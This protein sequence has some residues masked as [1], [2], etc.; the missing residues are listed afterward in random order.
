MACVYPRVFP[1]L[2][3][4]ST[5]LPDQAVGI[6]HETLAGL[7]VDIEEDRLQA[8]LDVMGRLERHLFKGGDDLQGPFV[9]LLRAQAASW[10][11]SSGPPPGSGPR[12][13]RLMIDW[14]RIGFD[15]R[16]LGFDLQPRKGVAQPLDETEALGRARGV[17]NELGLDSHALGTPRFERRTR[18][19]GEELEIRLPWLDPAAESM[20]GGWLV[21]FSQGR[22]S[23][24][25]LHW[26]SGE[27]RFTNEASL[28]AG[29]R[30][31]LVV[32]LGLFLAVRYLRFYDSGQVRIRRAVQMGM[33]VGAAGL[34]RFGM[35]FLKAWN[36]GTSIQILWL[37]LL[38]LGLVILGAI[39]AVL[40][41]GV[42]E[43]LVRRL[44]TA[45]L[46]AFEALL[47]GHWTNATVARSAW[48]GTMAGSLTAGV[49]L[50]L[51]WLMLPLGI[52]ASTSDVLGDLSIVTP[53]TFSGIPGLGL[54]SD[55]LFLVF[56]PLLATLCVLVPEIR[57]RF[58][59]WGAIPAV[60]LACFLIRPPIM[61]IPTLGVA[62]ALL[63]STALP[64]LLFLRWD[65]LTAL[66]AHC[67]FFMWIRL[68]PLSIVDDLTQQAGAWLWL[69]LLMSPMLVS[70]PFLRSGRELSYGYDVERDIPADVLRR[71][72]EQ[73]RRKVELETARRIQAS[74]LPDLPESIGRLRARPPL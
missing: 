14:V 51:G 38:L 23:A 46:A 29:F 19:E 60:L 74:I 69:G 24:L 39:F 37:G 65:L 50:G 73:A 45:K 59:P 67:V 16:V 63:V 64:V 6:A 66:L 8:H 1:L 35:F 11:V 7:G 54:I 10:V 9:D 44:S 41:W 30:W 28:I 17:L 49:L 2:P 58:G 21:R 61:P 4:G 53:T 56:P 55:Y 32:F 12:G 42:G 72:T 15:G 57:S 25:H 27:S 31:M 48:R 62:V 5:V 26:R 33:L 47:K 3:R 36:E 71:V 18:P 68:Y 34:G 20:N 13:E 22:P 40:I 70:A 52:R 43:P